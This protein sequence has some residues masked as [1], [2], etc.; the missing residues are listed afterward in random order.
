ML[1]VLKDLFLR[2][3]CIHARGKSPNR[4]GQPRPKSIST[5]RDA[6]SRTHRRYATSMGERL[7]PRLA[8]AVGVF[9]VEGTQGVPGNPNADPPIPAVPGETGTIYV[10]VDN[11]NSA[12]NAY[13][14]QTETGDLLVADNPGFL[15][16]SVVSG[17]E[18]YDNMLV[19]SGT[20]RSEEPLNALEWW[21]LSGGDGVE[22]ATTGFQLSGDAL[23][24]GTQQQYAFGLIEGEDLFTDLSPFNPNPSA[25]RLDFTQQNASGRQAEVYGSI[26]YLQPDGNFTTWYFSNFNTTTGLYDARNVTLTA[27]PGIS[28]Q[29]DSNFNQPWQNRPEFRVPVTTIS[30]SYVR[31]TSISI[32]ALRDAQDR[33]QRWNRRLEIQWNTKPVEP[34]VVTATYPVATVRIEADTQGGNER[35]PYTVRYDNIR[36][37]E[38]SGTL[39][40]RG[41]GY[42]LPGAF[43]TG[44]DG[45]VP[46]VG[47]LPGYLETR[48]E[49]E[50]THRSANE[51]DAEGVRE[52]VVSAVIDTRLDAQTLT[53]QF[54]YKRNEDFH[55]TNDTNFR[56]PNPDSA[57]FTVF[58][59]DPPPDQQDV[60]ARTVNGIQVNVVFNTGSNF[61]AD[62]I[63]NKDN[64]RDFLVPEQT[65]KRLV[66][67]VAETRVSQPSPLRQYTYPG[68]N[69]RAGR[70]PQLLST[71]YITW[72]KDGATSVTFAPG[73]E[74]ALSDITVD[75]AAVGSSISVDAPITAETL[76]LRATEITV[77]AETNVGDALYVGRST[78]LFDPDGT[79][80]PRLTQ[81]Q[82]NSETPTM[83][84][85]EWV[86]QGVEPV[87]SP[88][89]GPNGS[90]QQMLVPKGGEGYGYD[91]EN[92]PII[93]LEAP[94]PASGSV[95]IIDISGS[96]SSLGVRTPGS[97]LVNS[98]YV[99]PVASPDMFEMVQKVTIGGTYDFFSGG[100][101]VPEAIPLII[102][103]PPVLAM[104]EGRIGYGEAAKVTAA[105]TAGIASIEFPSL[106][107]TIQQTK[108]GQNT[109]NPP[110]SI[111]ANFSISPGD[112]GII[113][114]SA[115]INTQNIDGKIPDDNKQGTYSFAG[116]DTKA[117]VPGAGY[118]LSRS[119][120]A[121]ISL[122]NDGPSAT[123]G[124]DKIT[125]RQG[126]L[127]A[128]VTDGGLNYG[129]GELVGVNVVTKLAAGGISP[130]SGYAT[131]PSADIVAGSTF[132]GDEI[133][134]ESIT[135]EQTGSRELFSYLAVGM[136]IRGAGFA[137]DAT[138]AGVDFSA[139][140]VSI[141]LGGIIAESLLE[142]A[143]LYPHEY[144]VNN[145]PAEEDIR[146]LAATVT[147]AKDAAS[148]Q[149]EVQGGQL[150]S[151]S[152]VAP[153]D[154]PYDGVFPGRF[155]GS[156]YK[157]APD[158]SS[159][160]SSIMAGSSFFSVPPSIGGNIE[161]S[162]AE[163]V[164]AATGSNY[165][166]NS[167]GRNGVL[168]LP[169]LGGSTKGVLSLNVSDGQLTGRGQISRKGDGF[170]SVGTAIVDVPRPND[171]VEG[172]GLPAKF[173]AVVEP[174]GSIRQT[175]LI[176]AGSEYV[177]APRYFIEA[178]LRITQARATARVDLLTGVVVGVDILSAGSGFTSPPIVT[179]DPPGAEGAGR[180]ALAVAE[181]EGGKISK[182]TVVDGGSG[183]SSQAAVSIQSPLDPSVVESMRLNVGVTIQNSGEIYIADEKNTP[184]TGRGILAI[185]SE[186]T[187]G[188][189]K[190]TSLYVEA[191][192]SDI[193]ND[194]KIVAE[195]G[196][197]VQLVSTNAERFSGPFTFSSSGDGSLTANQLSLGL[198]NQIDGGTGDNSYFN[199]IDLDTSVSTLR[200][201]TTLDSQ[202]G[203]AA[204]YTMKID[205]GVDEL[206]IDAVLRAGGDI[207][208]K[209]TNTVTVESTVETDRGFE[210]VAKNFEVN[211]PISSRLGPISIR[212]TGGDISLKN[213]IVV[214]SPTRDLL[215]VDVKIDSA[216]EIINKGD[217]SALNKVE[218]R[219][220]GGVNVDVDVEDSALVSTEGELSVTSTAGGVTLRTAVT[221]AEIRAPG[222]S[223]I[224]VESDDIDVDVQA[225]EVDFVALGVDPGLYGINENALQGILRDVEIASVSAPNGS[226]KLESDK[227]TRITLDSS[228]L[229]D[230]FRDS[231]LGLEAA[232]NVEIRALA[233]EVVVKDAPLAGGSARSVRFGTTGPLQATYDPGKTGESVGRL[234]GTGV[235][236]E[237]PQFKGLDPKPKVG[238]LILVKNE[239][240]DPS[241][242]GIYVVERLGGGQGGFADWL[243]VR[244]D[245]AASEAGLPNGSFIHVRE[246]E[247]TGFY[248]VSYVP[249]R[250]QIVEVSRSSQFLADKSLLYG[251][252]VGARVL[253]PNVVATA[254]VSGIDW[255]NRVV[256]LGLPAGAEVRPLSAVE[257]R[258]L[259]EDP[260]RI[261]RTLRSGESP[262]YIGLEL[263]PDSQS[264]SVGADHPLVQ[265][266]NNALA[267]PGSHKGVRLSSRG[268]ELDRFA[269]AVGGEGN[270]ILLR[271]TAKG[272]LD[273]WRQMV[274]EFEV[275]TVYPGFVDMA[276]DG[277]TLNPAVRSQLLTLPIEEVDGNTIT[278]SKSFFRWD[279]IV[280]GQRL[281][282]DG[283]SD[284]AEVVS[285]SPTSRTVVLTDGSFPSALPNKVVV[286]ASET[287][288]SVDFGEYEM[289]Y[290]DPKSVSVQEIDAIQPG[291]LVVGPG[292]A[293]NVMVVAVD[294][295]RFGIA[296]LAGSN[297]S[298]GSPDVVG[299]PRVNVIERGT[300]RFVLGA[301]GAVV[302]DVV[303][304]GG[305]IGYADKL[306]LQIDNTFNDLSFNSLYLGM[307]V[308]G[309]GIRSGAKLLSID[310]ANRTVGI[311]PGSIIG[312][313]DSIVFTNPV[314]SI[315]DEL[316]SGRLSLELDGS[317]TLKVLKD[318]GVIRETLTAAVVSS[319]VSTQ[320]VGTFSDQLYRFIQ[321]SGVDKLS[322]LVQEA[323]IRFLDGLD[324]LGGQAWQQNVVLG[325]EV[326]TSLVQ[327]EGLSLDLA[328]GE[329][330][331]DIVIL[332]RA[333][334]GA[335]PEYLRAGTGTRMVG[336]VS[337]K[338]DDAANDDDKYKLFVRRWEHVGAT[339]EFVTQTVSSERE[340][341]D[342]EPVTSEENPNE[343][344]RDFVKIAL[345]DSDTLVVAYETANQ[346]WKEVEV[347]DLTSTF[348]LALGESGSG[349]GQQNGAVVFGEGGAAYYPAPPQDDAIV[350]AALHVAGD[351]FL[352]AYSV[353]DKHWISE[354]NAASGE[355]GVEKFR[356]AGKVQAIA[357][358][359]D[360]ETL[361]IGM[362]KNGVAVIADAHTSTPSLAVRYD[363]VESVD[364]IVSSPFTGAWG[365]LALVDSTGTVLTLHE[366][367]AFDRTLDRSRVVGIDYNAGIL[368]VTGD[369]FAVGDD[370]VVE[371]VGDLR[372]AI[373]PSA[374]F[375]FLTEAQLEPQAV[376]YDDGDG[377]VDS[378]KVQE[379]QNGNFE[380]GYV[381]VN[382]LTSPVPGDTNSDS[383]SAWQALSDQVSSLGGGYVYALNNRGQWV[384]F[385][386]LSGVDSYNRIVG[387]KAVSG[388]DA[389]PLEQLRNITEETESTSLMVALTHEEGTDFHTL[390]DGSQVRSHQSL[391]NDLA[392]LADINEQWQ[393]NEVFLTVQSARPADSGSD[394]PMFI[395]SQT[396][397]GR[398]IRLQQDFMFATAIQPGMMVTGD[399]ISEGSKVEAVDFL[400]NLVWLEPREN[401]SEQ[402]PFP[403]DLKGVG[404]AP[405]GRF[406]QFAY[407]AG[408]P[409]GLIVVERLGSVAAASAQLTGDVQ[410]QSARLVASLDEIKASPDDQNQLEKL[411]IGAEVLSNY[412]ATIAGGG[413]VTG[414]DWRIGLIGV[415][416]GAVLDSDRLVVDGSHA[417]QFRDSNGPLSQILSF[418]IEAVTTQPYGRSGG[419]VISV[420]GING[421]ATAQWSNLSVG[422][423]VYLEMI[424]EE[425]PGDR[426][427]LVKLGTLQGYDARLG[428]VYLESQTDAIAELLNYGLEDSPR[429]ILLD[430]SLSYSVSAGAVELVYSTDDPLYERIERET[431]RS[432]VVMQV[433]ELEASRSE[434][435][436][437]KRLG[438]STSVT[439]ASSGNWVLVG[440]AKNRPLKV[441][442]VFDAGTD[443]TLAEM[444]QIEGSELTG[445][446]LL[447]G[448]SITNVGLSS[449]GLFFKS[450]FGVVDGAIAA[451][452]AVS[453]AV[454]FEN[455][456]SGL[457]TG[458]YTHDVQGGGVLNGDLIALLDFPY[459]DHLVKAFHDNSAITIGAVGAKD[460]VTGGWL[461]SDSAVI[462]LDPENS[463]IVVEPY[464]ILTNSPSK[465]RFFINGE[466]AFLEP[467]ID[468]PQTSG[469]LERVYLPDAEISG[470][471]PGVDGTGAFSGPDIVNVLLQAN[472]SDVGGLPALRFSSF[473]RLSPHGDTKMYLVNDDGTLQ[474]I[475][476]VV[477][478]DAENLLIAVKTAGAAEASQVKEDLKKGEDGSS[479]EVRF[480]VGGLILESL[481]INDTINPAI[482]D[483]SSTI[484]DWVSGSQFESVGSQY[485]SRLKI[486]DPSFPLSQIQRG[487]IVTDD[488]G[489]VL[490]PVLKADGKVDAVRVIGVDLVNRVL[491][492]AFADDNLLIA[493]E[494]PAIFEPIGLVSVTITSESS[495]DTAQP[496]V[497]E[498]SVSGG[499]RQ[500]AGSLTGDFLWIDPTTMSF[501]RGAHQIGRQIVATPEGELGVGGEILGSTGS[502]GLVSVTPG[503]VVSR[504]PGEL[505][506]FDINADITA[507]SEGE[508]SSSPLLP[509]VASGSMF[510]SSR[511]IID[512]GS[513][514]SQ[515]SRANIDA[516]IFVEGNYAGRL[517]GLD[518]SIGLIGVEGSD[519]INISPGDVV[520][521]QLTE[522][523]Q[524]GDYQINRGSVRG[525]F[526]GSRLLAQIAG[527]TTLSGAPISTDALLLGMPVWDQ[528]DALIG[529]VT[530]VATVASAS[531]GDA[532]LVG[533]SANAAA[534]A[535]GDSLIPGDVSLIES[536]ERIRFG[537]RLSFADG[538]VIEAVAELGMLDGEMSVSA[539]GDL[540]ASGSP[541]LFHGLSGPRVTVT[542]QFPAVSDL[543]GASVSGV[544]VAPNTVVTGFD[545]QLGL[546]GLTSPISVSGGAVAIEITPVESLNAI[547]VAVGDASSSFIGDLNGDIRLVLADSV[548][549][550]LNAEPWLGRL[551]SID[552]SN[553]SQGTG[554]IRGIDTD[555]RLVAIDWVSKPASL[556]ST[557]AVNSI[558]VNRGAVVGH[559]GTAALNSEFDVGN[560]TTLFVDPSSLAYI[561]TSVE[562]Y[563]VQAS[564][565]GQ[566]LVLQ[567]DARFDVDTGMF[568]ATNGGLELAVIDSVSSSS[569][570]VAITLMNYWTG[571][572]IT[573]PDGVQSVLISPFTTHALEVGDSLALSNSQ[574]HF[575]RFAVQAI[576][577]K[578]GIIVVDDLPGEGDRR[579]AEWILEGVEHNVR[580]VSPATIVTYSGPLENSESGES[581][582]FENAR[583]ILGGNGLYGDTIF[584]QFFIGQSVG[585]QGLNATDQLVVTGIDKENGLIGMKVAGGSV[586]TLSKEFARTVV[587]PSTS[588]ILQSI[589]V[590][591]GGVE[592]KS[593]SRA[594][595]PGLAGVVGNSADKQS[596]VLLSVGS[597]FPFSWLHAAV[598]EGQ[599]VR[600]DSHTSDG[601]G[602]FGVTGAELVSYDPRLALI[603]ILYSPS[604]DLG[605]LGDLL[606]SIESPIQADTVN[607]GSSDLSFVTKVNAFSI[608]QPA[609]N[610]VAAFAHRLYFANDA[611]V[612]LG[613]QLGSYP[614]VSGPSIRG[615]QRVTSFGTDP[616]RGDY[617][618]IAAGGINQIGTRAVGGPLDLFPDIPKRDAIG[619]LESAR[620]RVVVSSIDNY[621]V[622]DVTR[623]A[624][625][626]SGSIGETWSRLS[627][628]GH[629]R[630]VGISDL[631][632]IQGYDAAN[633]LIFFDEGALASSDGIV[634]GV[635]QTSFDVRDS[636]SVPLGT[637]QGDT[638]VLR[639]KSKLDLRSIAIGD[640]LEGAGATSNGRVVGIN[641]HV[642][643]ITVTSGSI[644]QPA[645]MGEV[646]VVRTGTEFEV[647]PNR[648][649]RSRQASLSGVIVRIDPGFEQ[650]ERIYV[651]QSVAGSGLSVGASIEAID[652]DNQILYLSSDSIDVV[653]DLSD[654]NFSDTD[655]DFRA[656]V[657]KATDGTPKVT[658]GSDQTGSTIVGLL[659]GDL[660][661]LSDAS[662]KIFDVYGAALVGTT[663]FG[664][665][666]Q[667]PATVVGYD[668]ITGI[669]ALPEGSVQRS[670]L[671]NSLGVQTLSVGT[672]LNAVRWEF[673]T[674]DE[675]LAEIQIVD[676]DFSKASLEG[677]QSGQTVSG[678]GINPSAVV[679]SVNAK[680]GKFV[681]KSRNGAKVIDLEGASSPRSIGFGVPLTLE[682]G[683]TTSDGSSEVEIVADAFGEI[684]IRIESRPVN[685]VKVVGPA[686]DNGLDS[687]QMVT[688]SADTSLRAEAIKSF[689]SARK[690]QIVLG[691]GIM[692]GYYVYR[693]VLGSAGN[694]KLQLYNGMIY[695]AEEPRSPS[696]LDLAPVGDGKSWYLEARAVSAWAAGG[697]IRVIGMR[698]EEGHVDLVSNPLQMGVENVSGR[699]M[700]KFAPE[701]L[702]EGTLEL[703]VV[704]G[705]PFE[706]NLLVNNQA[707]TAINLIASDI[708]SSN[709]A[710]EAERVR[711]RALYSEIGTENAQGVTRFV[712]GVQPG[713]IGSTPVN[714][715]SPRSL[716]KMISVWK[717][718]SL[719]GIELADPNPAFT[720]QFDQSVRLIELGQELPSLNVPIMI[721]GENRFG[722]TASDNVVIDGSQIALDE[723]GQDSS[724][725]KTGG[726][727]GFVFVESIFGYDDIQ[728]QAGIQS[729]HFV[730]FEEGAAVVLDGAENILV[731][732]NDF[733]YD[734]S[735]IRRSNRFGV[736][737]KGESKN[738][739]V[740]ENT[741]AGSND[742][743][744]VVTDAAED[745]FIVGN[746]I[747][748]AETGAN[749]VGVHLEADGNY[750]GIPGDGFSAVLTG[751]AILSQEEV[752]NPLR[753]I[754]FQD[755][756]VDLSVVEVGMQVVL[757]SYPTRTLEVV[758]I[759]ASSR[760]LTIK[761]N[762]PD[763]MDPL[764]NSS[765][766]QLVATVGYKVTGEYNSNTLKMSDSIYKMVSDRLFVGQLISG[767]DIPAG[768]TIIGIGKE[769][770]SESCILTISNRLLGFGYDIE[771]SGGSDS[772]GSRLVAFGNQSS[773]KIVQSTTGVLLGVGWEHALLAINEK[774][775]ILLE[776]PSVAGRSFT[777]WGIVEKQKAEA[778]SAELYAVIEVLDISGEVTDIYRL[779]VRAIDSA[780]GSM[781]VNAAKLE[782]F[783]SS[784]SVWLPRDPG[785]V[786]SIESVRVM[787]SVGDENGLIAS[788]G[789]RVVATQVEQG[790][791]HA[792]KI[793]DNGLHAIGDA[794]AEAG[795]DVVR[796]PSDD[797]TELTSWAM[798]VT[799]PPGGGRKIGISE[800]QQEILRRMLE[801]WDGVERVDDNATT[802][803][804]DYNALL[805]GPDIEIKVYGNGVMSDVFL[806]KVQNE[807]GEWKLFL[808]KQDGS[809]V[810]FIDGVTG[811]TTLSFG[812]GWY[813]A[814]DAEDLRGLRVGDSVVSRRNA[815]ESRAPG[816]HLPEFT[817]VREIGVDFVRLST[818]LYGQRIQ[819]SSN[820]YQGVE[821]FQLRVP[822]GEGPQPLTNPRQ[823][824]F[825]N[826]RFGN[827]IVNNTGAGV[828]M[829]KAAAAAF[830]S[831]VDLGPD[832][833]EVAVAANI[834][835]LLSTDTG[836][837][838]AD[839][840][841]GQFNAEV[842]RVLYGLGF[843]S[844]TV[845][846]K[847]YI[848]DW[849]KQDQFGNT[850][851]EEDLAFVI[852]LPSG[853]TG[854]GDRPTFWYL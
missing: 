711:Q 384:Y 507:W 8:L 403:Q 493:D 15:S 34:P 699:D 521:V 143:N 220:A 71:E 836:T 260:S 576:D 783:D 216:G 811:S 509:T 82:L 604:F 736:V 609:S 708:A 574:G 67:V 40:N 741:F 270:V 205:N 719:S 826:S 701:L 13:L 180:R 331:K 556:T 291:M 638:L 596:T 625:R 187:L 452:L 106:K 854:V 259:L 747:G 377:T 149:A 745:N 474:E 594:A 73:L 761:E 129:E 380:Q 640:R 500:V 277:R 397:D 603:E 138:V 685:T 221:R 506:T 32:E 111:S 315:E 549:L 308:E 309:Q 482:V 674:E 495:Q 101:I 815:G 53:E 781:D 606:V 65:D 709:P 485:V 249:S 841:G 615:Y 394:T 456:S 834:F 160:V 253:G 425:L 338:V 292:L 529:Y 125:F 287:P 502:L 617:L 580:L 387:L 19:L 11:S 483:S 486:T 75:L 341:V 714:N 302:S 567:D 731:G 49:V 727:H 181:I 755:S 289:I 569:A 332:D 440:G 462:G 671:S 339:D 42:R 849:D 560:R 321:P 395:G 524:R 450:N 443:L 845:P 439:R 305:D 610:T 159:V 217:I 214:S 775:L 608:T 552:F 842:F 327:F 822:P 359:D 518:L 430:T 697:E 758:A 85:S 575:N 225:F 703:D 185:S 175:T 1:T 35:V 320:N 607:F 358:A 624:V 681:I 109:V 698:T 776:D 677:V 691:P 335:V 298:W 400:N 318:E 154:L 266:I 389:S 39:S 489:L 764:L 598:G 163:A 412:E 568:V 294:T 263:A 465:V 751:L 121:T 492:I 791:Q 441:S 504:Q 26:S 237:E 410:F 255:A 209:S 399:G 519:V 74:I 748:L 611:G 461:R 536:A 426:R 79:V 823:I 33:L 707:F 538:G 491:A 658:F 66:G 792:V 131:S 38:R 413:T 696:D 333:S 628:G 488:N 623:N 639:D 648:T 238:D 355:Y 285:I 744:I 27:G 577:P 813:L 734:T 135:S 448:S 25:S 404:D 44:A 6:A 602:A 785:D 457:I 265:S 402:E 750:L 177:T 23:V 616:E 756:D 236:T 165:L 551:I 453:T 56:V 405:F 230:E 55:L 816:K 673:V 390:P 105:W 794:R 733:G 286:A 212:T 86:V 620:L 435:N 140:V 496:L 242:N 398:A 61:L 713:V 301:D 472:G 191:R 590:G 481:S 833:R 414:V 789:S 57:L 737:I 662:Y 297:L 715:R 76:D 564:K 716:G 679:V 513:R 127:A 634:A 683:A 760:R 245:G 337:I 70:Q 824:S 469:L 30:D 542:G 22:P 116:G 376:R 278:V 183:Y 279:V 563:E 422:G 200:V 445:A 582:S 142:S 562:S 442:G 497:F 280:P 473:D 668:P 382:D 146:G 254:E 494:T 352:V 81:R 505:E 223:V 515:L 353:E 98:T 210:I 409:N 621:V 69:V 853:S 20:A 54:S 631:G 194:G 283:L 726:T 630:A 325:Q 261:D 740:F 416:N 572:Q 268:G 368:S 372:Y 354:W 41:I 362:G 655:G 687:T 592:G 218:M 695:Q 118:D 661:S 694:V 532:F 97:G 299:T 340:L 366:V 545:E 810:V 684:P 798:D 28:A 712:V 528:A 637:T 257:L 170:S 284:T 573:P 5:R 89:F 547:S 90:I 204:P 431:G 446:G 774:A 831:Q 104:D 328:E 686:G 460:A 584:E 124:N 62:N 503:V 613:G 526:G 360:G 535:A 110:N 241:S 224:L 724:S 557:V 145:Q 50:T 818:P 718:T 411:V 546:L 651:G 540:T 17:V 167:P 808:K 427:E 670:A 275:F 396:S 476:D 232:G 12:P 800:Q 344:E 343:W 381:L 324:A 777:G 133:R 21:I 113:R 415:S 850:F 350:T 682:L 807:S 374:S 388:T 432:A 522:L 196:I 541:T 593:S 4:D 169:V 735:N 565:S 329:E 809:D 203:V 7:E 272:D 728:K 561:Q 490:K 120:T 103:D 802:S 156:G 296:V 801:D 95:E 600:I 363:I 666:L 587:D 436:S 449:A 704:I 137:T 357:Q 312:R 243:L 48:F 348:N 198:E 317:K 803:A 193:M 386:R 700:G 531:V 334:L 157:S 256:T 371:R 202:T 407:V 725:Y 784:A 141:S 46:S 595:T 566:S 246:G 424:Q 821:G 16:P 720:F 641:P 99:S 271:S 635:A 190:L 499:R 188:S 484:S 463:I 227:A 467:E 806:D 829:A 646:V 330:L 311:T 147:L 828:V 2:Q 197:Q 64:D 530:G 37:I 601:G 78:N 429:L 702:V 173:Q 765:L 749:R 84:P 444:A 692:S 501:E 548:V 420:G 586:S 293:S 43:T 174:D 653:G 171:Y 166:A 743:A 151:V 18:N 649:T 721:D 326:V 342:W 252:D 406:V 367:D 383:V 93:A 91:P 652:K 591:L 134:I 539:S 313:V 773:N 276:S 345:K 571:Q 438:V 240:E 314:Y 511:G 228:L 846:L 795:V 636:R 772:G 207:S 534:P 767:P 675:L 179:L 678:I 588:S 468:I 820:D 319:R 527:L 72:T 543:L 663:V 659:E 29:G 570:G 247:A 793:L 837:Q 830:L 258:G 757:E 208:I 178:P 498:A 746:T 597:D 579:D 817:E 780:A 759:D 508:L 766:Q 418:G 419:V 417:V 763:G 629:A 478:V 480:G 168:E 164:V 656:L 161:G 644:I 786:S 45:G 516:P 466:R 251:L 843:E 295:S 310:T 52:P 248:Q 832:M 346:G 838:V 300:G 47:R 512:Y 667:A 269:V 9:T 437:V 83:L 689:S 852:E 459:F 307:S 525:T 282:G 369:A 172:E 797:S 812:V 578:L 189:D 199:T 657:A 60:T 378:G 688:R 710:I 234:E 705:S 665:I 306:L 533:I 144:F 768:T 347:T 717:A 458:S 848:N 627:I 585:G 115:V 267:D 814:S 264:Q 211:S 762:K 323:R 729:L 752:G 782:K 393:G 239:Y 192:A 176:D 122:S 618:T 626:V 136:P 150:V 14:K 235:L 213:D 80:R 559:S 87:L 520:D 273:R 778:G 392:E 470:S 753:K 63:F 614:V 226:I 647:D 654:L 68:I 676:D 739:T 303:R 650:Y 454:D 421:G 771:D 722:G 215:A 401:L 589:Y 451:E 201:A 391:D 114:N 36:Q 537:G 361:V 433:T 487:D 847:D 544:G 281:S 643:T 244:E 3:R 59:D 219:S 184:E 770:E 517:T 510:R 730:G 153:S 645:I 706:P 605:Q 599:A 108:I 423:T 619:N 351:N 128:S 385:A 840:R 304:A 117:D 322:G 732:K 123:V 126:I 96:V 152:V 612:D 825:V 31:P 464:S 434:V 132:F 356:P 550:P 555:S 51:S 379:V 10:H 92:P 583:A 447:G 805:N 88:V 827:I 155:G 693:P 839:N 844:G 186:A 182:I 779:P 24:T 738:N 835:G 804:A 742:T 787:F 107:H 375:T 796:E 428:H 373:A 581:H 158:L 222:Q 364:G 514:S 262:E 475:G 622:G 754:Q 274:E 680:E 690:D 370:L 664:G 139:G 553:N 408:R 365:D 554:V 290:L 336:V 94:A 288:N 349:S 769:Q 788:A 479:K 660:V 672:G 100:A 229:E 206:A 58:P 477:G 632:A 642:G 233:A 799:I 130:V 523:S 633:R 148:V 558:V 231:S 112:T 819:R 102:V 790:Y 119:Y 316:R 455:S 162:V 250:K 77:N 851:A 471:M 669:I 195:G 723:V